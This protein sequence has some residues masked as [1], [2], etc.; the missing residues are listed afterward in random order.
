MYA[1]GQGVQRDLVEAYAWLHRA[2]AAGVGPAA[3]Y[4]Q[5]VAARMGPALLAQANRYAGAA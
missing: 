5:R 2:G 4:I 3:S 1:S